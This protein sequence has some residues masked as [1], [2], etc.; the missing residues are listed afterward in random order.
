MKAREYIEVEAKDLTDERV[1]LNARNEQIEAEVQALIQERTDNITR[2]DEIAIEIGALR[3][4]LAALQEHTPERKPTKTE[5]RD[6]RGIATTLRSDRQPEPVAP[7]APAPG[8]PHRRS[9]PDP[10]KAV[11]RAEKAKATQHPHHLIDPL[12]VAPKSEHHHRESRKRAPLVHTYD[13]NDTVLDKRDLSPTNVTRAE[14]AL[15]IMREHQGF[16]SQHELGLEMADLLECKK[17]TAQAIVSKCIRLLAVRKQIV[18]TGQKAISRPGT[19][20]YDSPIWKIADEER[21]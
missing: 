3:R 12:S 1:Q 21:H 10:M 20:R 17:T 7:I 18:Y 11:K 14:L 8:T 16:I 19:D 13:D 6:N 2:C 4:A 5:P 15:D 9:K